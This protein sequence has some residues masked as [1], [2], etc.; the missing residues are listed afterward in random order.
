MDF[1]RLSLLVKKISFETIE[2]RFVVSVSKQEITDTFCRF[3]A[4]QK[5]EILHRMKGSE[6]EKQGF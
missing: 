3:G 2:P 5:F 1:Q 6:T 4:I